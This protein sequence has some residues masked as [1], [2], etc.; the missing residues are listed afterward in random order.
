MHQLAQSAAFVEIQQSQIVRLPPP[1]EPL[2]CA[3][4]RKLV[5]VVYNAN[6]NISDV[7]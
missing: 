5:I 4:N 2:C 1:N 6:K 7:L 3:V